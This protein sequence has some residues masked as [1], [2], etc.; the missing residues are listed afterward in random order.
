MPPKQRRKTAAKRRAN[1]RQKQQPQQQYD[2]TKMP[3]LNTNF[4]EIYMGC[5]H[6]EPVPLGYDTSLFQVNNVSQPTIN[7]VGLF[8]SCNV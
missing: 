6:T 4:K 2:I 1:R 5:C 3:A 8:G 7:T